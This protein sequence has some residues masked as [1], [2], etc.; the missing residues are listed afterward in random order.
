MSLQEAVKHAYDKRN[1]MII[2]GLTGRTGSGCTTLAKILTCNNY[3]DLDLRDTKTHG[4]NNIDERKAYIIDEFMKQDENWKPFVIIDVSSLILYEVFKA[5][6]KELE[7][8]INKLSE[9]EYKVW[10]DYHFKNCERKDLMGYSSHVLY[11]CE[12]N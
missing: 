2:L 6:K 11:I 12:K 9:E 7:E 1:E 5:G 3:D 4:Y 8:Y 10:L